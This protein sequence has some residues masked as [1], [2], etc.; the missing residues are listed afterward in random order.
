V[1]TF[2]GLLFGYDTGVINGALISMRHDLALTPATEGLVTSALLLGAA[3]GAITGGRLAD[4][5]GRRLAILVLAVIFFAGA[6]SC[7]LAP[8]VVALVGFRFLLGIAVGG[9][10]VVVPTYLAEISPAQRR[11]RIVTKNE[12]MIVT[13][14]LIAFTTNALIAHYW[15]QNNGIWRWMI[16]IA[17]VPA[18]VLGL[19]MLV[20]PESPRW[21]ASRHRFPEALRALGII[22][23]QRGAEKELEEIRHLTKC[24][25]SSVPRGWAVIAVPWV[26]H[27]FL[28][29]IG[30]GIVQQVTGVNSIMYYGTRILAQSGFGDRA[31]LFANILNGV[32][33]VIA[34]FGGIYLLG[35]LGRRPMLIVGL[36]GTTSTLLLIGLFSKFVSPSGLLAYL[37]L[38]SMVM[39]LA[40]QQSLVSPVTWVLL[41]EIFPL[42]LRGIGMGTATFILWIANASIAFVFP[43]LVAT[44]GISSTFF[45]FVALGFLAAAFT[46]R[47]VPETSGR[48]L[49]AIESYFR[50][51]QAKPN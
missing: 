35:K 31:A 23:A 14:Q 18:V 1:A 43:S 30:I 13:G 12:L 34:T 48:S 41:S 24:E 5:F 7:S 10:S 38:F 20:M 25:E 32:V 33:S 11:G 3:F 51:N 49:E 17:V 42:W 46:I 28:L 19:G 44:F 21:L 22:R 39:F 8:G 15:Y 29:G 16:A 45:V 37:I 4:R 2:G 6:L 40:F 26:R 47:Y 50:Q 9:A 36:V 27:I